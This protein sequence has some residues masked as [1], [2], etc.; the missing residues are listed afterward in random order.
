[1]SGTPSFTQ[2]VMGVFYEDSTDRNFSQGGTTNGRPDNISRPMNETPNAVIDRT[3]IGDFMVMDATPNARTTGTTS[4][5]TQNVKASKEEA[6]VQIEAPKEE[7]P[8]TP[9]ITA[10]GFRALEFL[11][12]AILFAS[13][14]ELKLFIAQHIHG[15]FSESHKNYPST[16]R[17]ISKKNLKLLCNA[18]YEAISNIG[19]KYARTWDD[20]KEPILKKLDSEN[21]T[22]GNLDSIS[23]FIDWSWFQF[24]ENCDILKKPVEG[25]I[26]IVISSDRS[27]AEDLR[28]MLARTMVKRKSIVIE[29]GEEAKKL[30]R[31][32]TYVRDD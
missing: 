3:P 8:Y 12:R 32:V 5:T 2:K 17:P 16:F 19:T 13:K 28:N 20:I 9:I 1:M 21:A 26:S 15:F 7:A 6:P 27:K 11:E 29:G 25:Y 14:S 10:D 22:W 18:L 30:K 24:Y 31:I 4:S 23:T